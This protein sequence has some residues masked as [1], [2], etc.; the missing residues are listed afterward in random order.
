MSIVPKHPAYIDFA[1][2]YSQLSTDN[3]YFLD[4]SFLIAISDASDRF[5]RKAFPFWNKLVDIEAGLVVN[6]I[7]ISEFVHVYMRILYRQHRFSEIK[8]EISKTKGTIEDLKKAYDAINAD[9][10]W[11]NI[12]SNNPKLTAPFFDCVLAKLIPLIE[13]RVLEIAED[14]R[15]TILDAFEL[16]KQFHLGP[17]DATIVASTKKLDSLLVTTDHRL[18]NCLSAAPEPIVVVYSTRP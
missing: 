17:S 12:L 16:K 9:K 5:H 1:S 10:E 6:G 13:N 8:K 3:F 7:V 4:T 18:I 11:D 15:S 14:G 2:P